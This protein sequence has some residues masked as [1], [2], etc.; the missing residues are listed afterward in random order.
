[1]DA[2]DPLVLEERVNV[3]E[4]IDAAYEDVRRKHRKADRTILSVIE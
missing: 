2:D 4:D 1:V 3:D